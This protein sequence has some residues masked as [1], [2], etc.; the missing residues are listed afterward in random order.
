MPKLPAAKNNNKTSCLAAWVHKALFCAALYR[1]IV[2][3]L[4]LG[5]FLSSMTTAIVKYKKN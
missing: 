3:G 2:V 4:N 1:A 5:G